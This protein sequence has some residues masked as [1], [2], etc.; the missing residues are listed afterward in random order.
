MV[1]WEAKHLACHVHSSDHC[2]WQ[3]D[4]DSE[5]GLISFT[6]ETAATWLF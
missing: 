2:N 5:E 1:T 6:A 3:W 4:V